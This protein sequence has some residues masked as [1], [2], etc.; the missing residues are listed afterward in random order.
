MPPKATPAAMDAPPSQQG[1][2]AEEDGARSGFPPAQPM[3]FNLAFAV[4]HQDPDAT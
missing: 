1:G 3:G 4:L 2:Q